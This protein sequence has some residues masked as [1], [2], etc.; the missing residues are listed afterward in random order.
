MGGA[1][2]EHSTYIIKPRHKWFQIVN[3]KL[4]GWCKQCKLLAE[5]L[6]NIG[7]K[8]TKASLDGPD[9]SNLDGT[10]SAEGH[11]LT[12][13]LP[14]EDLLDMFTKDSGL[15]YHQICWFEPNS[16]V[17]FGAKKKHP[18]NSHPRVIPGRALARVQSH[19]LASW[20]RH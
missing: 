14:P 7:S 1:Y 15:L 10:G 6:P 18:S 16:C 17:D 2:R 11:H 9:L 8:W 20:A 4:C 13:I 12:L 19:R 3:I 5:Q